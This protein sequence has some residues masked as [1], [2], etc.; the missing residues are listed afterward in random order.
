MDWTLIYRDHAAMER[1]V[2]SLPRQVDATTFD[3]ERDD[4]VPAGLGATESV[5]APLR[6]DSRSASDGIAASVAKELRPKPLS[7]TEFHCL[8]RTYS[9]ASA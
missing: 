2:W 1:L 3:D 9:R 4:C 5:G 7:T 6:T 8:S